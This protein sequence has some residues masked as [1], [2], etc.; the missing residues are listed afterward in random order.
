L[1]RAKCS[2]FCAIVEE[3]YLRR[4]NENSIVVTGIGTVNPIG[5][6]AQE[7]WQSLILGKSGISEIT[8]FDASAFSTR[9]AGQ[10]SGFDPANYLSVKDI[11]KMDRLA[12]YAL[13]A[14]DEAWNQ[15]GLGNQAFDAIRCG[16]SWASGNG[17]IESIDQA[18]LDYSSQKERP[19]FSPYFQSKALPDSASGWI[20][21]RYNLK[22]P[23]QLSVAA[24][25]S[26]NVALFTAMLYMQAGHCD[27]ML[28]GGSD[29]PIT[30]S[31]L[32]GFGSMKALSTS[33][34]MH[35]ASRPFAASRDGFVL[36]EGAATLVLETYAHA[37]SRNATILAVLSGCG[38]ANDAFHPTAAEEQG[39][40]TFHSVNMALQMA[41]LK[42]EAIDL[43]NPHAT[44]TPNGDLAEYNGLYRVF[45]KSLANIPMAATK[46]MTGHLLGAAGALEAVCC[47]LSLQKQHLPSGRN[48]FELEPS[49]AERGINVCEENKAA[50]IRHA[51]SHSAG[52]GGHNASVIFSSLQAIR[53]K[54]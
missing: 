11:R 34:N 52:F 2:A 1:F 28:V 30:P 38:N 12:W 10:L 8:R 6:S 18:L 20:A 4:V 25:A 17:G 53:A 33:A 51:L 42:P 16:V 44:S 54:L 14:C 27:L 29:A 15:S 47:I 9:F 41:G 46:A 7:T 3:A 39:S 40:G 48:I 35:T 45:G 26:S 43:I 13:A 49:I 19:R 37:K 36:G 24:C 22:G 21:A 50:E 31:V 23:N 32:G 5:N